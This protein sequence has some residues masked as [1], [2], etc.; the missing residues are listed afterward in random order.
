MTTRR[1]AS[2]TTRWLW[3]WYWRDRR[4]WMLDVVLAGRWWMV[5]SWPP[6]GLYGKTL[7]R[8]G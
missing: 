8:D 2:S 7:K 3:F 6:S 4:H 5:G 1:A